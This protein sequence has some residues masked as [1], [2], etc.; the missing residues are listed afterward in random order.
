MPELNFIE[1]L[2]L[3]GTFVFALSGT[4]AAANQRFDVF[5]AFIIAFVTAVG[6]GTLRDVLIGA[7]PVGW[8][9]DL[10]YLY[11]IIAAVFVAYF[12]KRHILKLRKTL[13]LFDTIGIAIFTILGLEKT[14]A[15]GL[16][17]EVAIMMGMVSA[18]FGGVMRDILCNLVPLIFQ[19][20]IYATA[21]LIG[22]VLYLIL[23]HYLSQ[24]LAI[25]TTVLAI[26]IIR[27]AAV[28]NRWSL[29]V[30]R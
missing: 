24:N 20:E 9:Q 11:L 7:H 10:R 19:K 26:I 15:I 6:G 28:K 17:P 5:G 12:F 27:I 29:P 18:V 13:F 25:T 8:M 30:I 4:L 2:D 14:L 1:I 16:S 22:A 3:V 23:C 21:C